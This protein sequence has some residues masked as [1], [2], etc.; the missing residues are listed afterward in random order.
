MSSSPIPTVLTTLPPLASDAVVDLRRYLAA[1][2]DPRRRRGIRLTTVV[3][4]LRHM[5]RDSD[6]PL[7]LL[8]ITV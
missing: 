3:A 2:P 5:A 7:R 1:V 8:G 6:R 4:G